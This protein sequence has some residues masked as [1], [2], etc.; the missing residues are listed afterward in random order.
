MRIKRKKKV[1][2]KRKFYDPKRQLRQVFLGFQQ[3][4]VKVTEK[5]TLSFCTLK[6]V[7]LYYWFIP[8]KK[9]HKISFW[10]EHTIYLLGESNERP[11]GQKRINDNVLYCKNLEIKMDEAIISY[12]IHWRS[13]KSNKSTLDFK[14]TIFDIT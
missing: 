7:F 2:F 3:S 4:E 14:K 9:Y 6:T 11:Y 5:R 1:N 12:A 8:A 10:F 13:W